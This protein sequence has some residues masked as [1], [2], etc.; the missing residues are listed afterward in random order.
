M[1]STL[2]ERAP[3]SIGRPATTRSWLANRVQRVSSRERL[4]LVLLVSVLTFCPALIAAARQSS[5]RTR[6]VFATVPQRIPAPGS[7]QS[8]IRAT[9]RAPTFRGITARPGT[10]R[11][12][13]T[14]VLSVPGRTPKQARRLATLVAARVVSSSTIA[15][16]TWALFAT[17]PRLT[18]RVLHDARLSPALRQRLG[19]LLAQF[20][21]G[22]PLR[23]ESQSTG[24][25]GSV[26]EAIEGLRQATTVRRSPVWVG[27]AGFLVGIGLCALWLL[28]PASAQARG[29]SEGAPSPSVTAGRVVPN[30]EPGREAEPRASSGR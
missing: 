16:R 13:P 15:Y 11:G 18:Q 28:L 24:P 2:D 17:Q 22:E 30:H 25:T 10:R 12:R 7:D 21:P 4:L 5:Y 29:T 14:V 3:G 27:A 1:T 6:I 26:D 20:K 23:V 19:R 8:L 9:L